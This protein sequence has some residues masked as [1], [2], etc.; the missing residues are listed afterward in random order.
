[1]YSKTLS[2][3]STKTISSYQPSAAVAA[4]TKDFSKYFGMGV[5][6]LEKSFEELNFYSI[7][8]RENKD[9][10]T[11][12][13]FVDETI[14]DPNEEW[15]WKGTRSMAR[16]KALDMHAHMT[17]VLAV[18]GAIAQNDRQEEDR[19]MSYAMGDIL[20]W[21]AHNSEYAESYTDIMMGILYSPC[22]WMGI[23]Y[24]ESETTQKTYDDDD[25]PVKKCVLDQELSGFRTP[26]YTVDQILINNVR[27]QNTQRQKALIKRTYKTYE[28][29]EAIHGEHPNWPYVQRG[30]KTLYSQ[31]EGLFYD[32]KDDEHPDLC[33]EAIG[34]CR[35]TDTE[36]PFVGG[37]YLG[38]DDVD[39]NRISH[40]DNFDQAKYPFVAFG[41]ERI[42][43]HFFYWKSLMNRV[44]WDD[45]LLD[46]MYENTMNRE[47]LDLYSPLAMFGVEE[48]SSNVIFPSSVVSFENKDARAERILPPNGRSGY[49][50]MDKIE[51]SIKDKTLSDT[52]GGELPD[53]SQKAYTVQKAE[54]NARTILKGAL[55]SISFSVARVGD[56]MKDVAINH[57]STIQW[58]EITDAE[59]YRT[60]LLKDQ[61]VN[62]KKASKR[63]IFDESLIGN[64][65]SAEEKR[66]EELKM[67]NGKPL[68]KMKDHVYRLNPHLF[69]KMKYIISIIPEQMMEK[70]SA[71]QKSMAERMY[72]MLRKDPLVSGEGLVRKVLTANFEDEAEDLM[73]DP[74]VAQ[75]AAEGG[76]TKVNLSNSMNPGFQPG[77]G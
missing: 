73:A 69:S 67:L 43:K 17:A 49:D 18:P 22:Q 40:R 65:M 46:A 34:Y 24:V 58:D 44:G 71:F 20:Q 7:I 64:H 70:N 59:S 35:R 53:A 5:G 77:A 14:E 52:M 42:H 9:Q 55:R 45:S 60:L 74:A 48:F 11:W 72:A 32:T 1:M 56:L 26:V 4:I 33:E 27:E 63:I 75:V 16:D 29:L 8:Q 13:S 36:V 15:K 68:S 41:Y 6:I 19:Q 38:D 57:L 23:E 61:F 47:T 21:M 54:Q 50:A 39:W 2:D 3:D 30:I 31:D 10:R 76:D 51:S 25:I 12:N 37:I 28:D 62:G 66:D